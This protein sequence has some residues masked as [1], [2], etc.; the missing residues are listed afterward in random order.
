KLADT[1]A[2]VDYIG[3]RSTRIRTIDRTVLSVPNGQIANASIET[4]S[5]RDKFWF[6]HV[7]GLRYETTADQMRAVVKGTRS[8]LGVHPMVDRNESIRV[9]FF[10]LGQFS[11]D[12]EV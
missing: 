3:L 1:L 10:R 12:I 2:T 8:Y 6:H 9:L 5:A 11:F 7:I 4:L